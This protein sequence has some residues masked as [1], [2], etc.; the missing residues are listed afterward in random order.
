MVVCLECNADLH[1]SQLMSLS[2]ASVKSRLVLPIWYRLTQV[3]LD[4]GPLNRCL[5]AATLCNS[6]IVQLLNMRNSDGGFASYETKRGGVLLEL[7]NPSEVFG[8]CVVTFCS[9]LSSWQQDDAESNGWA[10]MKFW[11]E[12]YWHKEQ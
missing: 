4:K 5:R 8:E 1:M 7:L 2:F 10:V 9:S 3:V 12:R 6:D 11:I